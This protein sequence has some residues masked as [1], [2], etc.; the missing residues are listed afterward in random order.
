MSLN[1]YIVSHFAIG[2]I[3]FFLGFLILKNN[4]K[5]IIN[6][7][8]FLL[9]TSIAIWAISYGIWL[10]SS[11]QEIALFWARTLNFGSSL[12]PVFYLHW[13]ISVLKKD[14]RKILTFYYFFTLVFLIFGYS[15]VFISGTQQILQFSFFP[16]ANW[17]Y[18]VW[19]IFG[20]GFVII[21]TQIL[22]LKEISKSNGNYR[23]Q[24]IYI[25]IG[26]LIGFVGG[27]TNHLLMLGINWF[28][29]IG[30]PLVVAYPII[31]A[32]AIIKHRL[33]DIKLV[34]RRSSVFL[35]SLSIVLLI[36]IGVKYLV[37]IY[38]IEVSVLL[39]FLILIVAVYYFPI[40]RKYFYKVANKYLF[41]S[42]YD[43]RE[44]IAELS[45][46][47]R[48]TLEI[49][50]IYKY[51]S[52]TLEHAFHSTAIGVL[53]FNEKKGEYV[54][55]HNHGFALN[56]NKFFAGDKK[57]YK[58]FIEKNKSIV[59]E[60]IRQSNLPLGIS[61]NKTIKLLEKMK[62]DILTPLNIKDRTI[63]LI[64]LGS[65]ESR[66]MYNDEDLQVLEVIGAQAAIAIENAILYE[67]QKNFNIKLEKEV[68]KA[69]HDL[70]KANKQLIKL[71]E[72]KSEFISIASHQLRT[73]LTVVKGYISMILE[74]N[75]GEVTSKMGDPLEK[76]YESNDRLIKLVENLL[77]VSRIESGRMQFEAQD[78][79]LEDLVA[80][81]AEELTSTAKKKKIKL[82]LKNSKKVLPKVKID[83]EKIRQVVMNLID[84][85]IKYTK[86]GSV[87]VEVKKRDD[88]IR[89]CVADSGMGID[90]KDQI[91]LFKKFYRG[92]GTVLIH[93]EGTGLGLYVARNM[94]TMHKG[95]IW[96][97]SK[98]VGKGSKFCFE[99]PIETIKN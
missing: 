39:D 6:L 45:E 14:N 72:A 24:I 22:L 4:W 33:M 12:I 84:N 56:G 17:L 18:V 2:T 9:S 27:S 46:K 67:E 1:F 55:K 40:L 49:S 54:V 77:N 70:K 76:I 8:Y 93:T 87:T 74:K 95:K 51:I 90:P 25:Y 21:Y 29:P 36:A 57:L 38:F 63:G 26:S 11:S 58:M 88:N 15:K 34:M 16:Q 61:G 80:S 83:E 20:W 89:F 79:H 97:E 52:E 65:K 43:S 82:I 78:M 92:E 69:T 64:A 85:A 48:F 66:D 37:A 71:D 41:S 7:T 50:S 47:L 30:S 10:L 96:A 94:L 42:M 3:A 31:F 5:N 19:L 91:N 23:L 53:I 75:F 98:G 68:E 32:Y 44:V 35:M 59:T 62:V 28:P 99:L 86:E 81:V 13:I 60:E 73:P